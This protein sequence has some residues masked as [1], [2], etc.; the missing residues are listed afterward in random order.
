MNIAA[1]RV[2]GEFQLDALAELNYEIS[3][4]ENGADLL[5]QTGQTD[6]E[7]E[8]MLKMN[9]VID[10]APEQ[11]KDELDVN[12]LEFALTSDQREIVEEALGHVKATQKLQAINVRNLNGA[13]LFVVA[14]DYLN[15][16]HESQEPIN[17]V[18][19]AQ[20]EPNPISIA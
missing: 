4:L 18:E 7:I 3:Q 8:S 5:K 1:N 2:Q 11:P 16:L 20:T 19:N 13:A 6:E 17:Q 14:Q 15:R 9:G 10:D 12:K